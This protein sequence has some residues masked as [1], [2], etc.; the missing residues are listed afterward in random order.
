VE[1]VVSDSS[2]EYFHPEVR[3][4]HGGGP[5][6]WG[7]LMK[8]PGAYTLELRALG[9]TVRSYKFQVA[10]G[11]IARIPQNELGYAGADALP[12][13]SLIADVR[14]QEFWLAPIQ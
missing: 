9:K 5:V 8:A 14:M 13:Q 1:G 6:K 3:T 4:G 11:K 10:G 2:W 7:T 12:P